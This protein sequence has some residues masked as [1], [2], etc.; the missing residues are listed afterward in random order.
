M[1][2]SFSNPF[3]SLK[4]LI[5]FFRKDKSDNDLMRYVS[6]RAN[7]IGDAGRFQFSVN[8][9]LTPNREVSSNAEAYADLQKA[10]HAFGVLDFHGLINH[11]C[12]T[13]ATG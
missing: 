13:Q 6:Q 7:P 8:G 10:L 12:W 5:A 3:H 2:M 9:V 1:S 4:T 11:S